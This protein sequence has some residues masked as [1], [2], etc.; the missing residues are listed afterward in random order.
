MRGRDVKF[1]LVSFAV[2]LALMGMLALQYA[3]GNP[4]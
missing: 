2:T 3:W 1:W 4:R